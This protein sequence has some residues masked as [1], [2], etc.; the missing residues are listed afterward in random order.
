MVALL[1]FGAMPNIRVQHLRELHL[2][3]SEIEVPEHGWAMV[4]PAEPQPDEAVVTT[5]VLPGGG[6]VMSA[7]PGFSHGCREV[8]HNG[9]FVGDARRVE[10]A[11]VDGCPF[12]ELLY[13]PVPP[14][15]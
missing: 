2:C 5:E 13:A 4:V 15:E 9:A 3:Q 8:F 12:V 14:V 7:G 11:R 6:W 1:S 10:E